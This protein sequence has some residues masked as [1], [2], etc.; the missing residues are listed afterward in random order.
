[1][2]KKVFTSAISY[3]KHKKEVEIV[4]EMLKKQGYQ[5]LD[6][7]L[8]ESSIIKIENKSV[9]KFLTHINYK[10]KIDKRKKKT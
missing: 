4:K 2:T 7:F 1:M 5:V 6:D 9:G 10:L 8:S 3:F